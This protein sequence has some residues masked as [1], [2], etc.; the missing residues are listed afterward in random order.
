MALLL[1][2]YAAHCACQLIHALHASPHV[3]TH[4]HTYF[5]CTC[6][7]T[8]V[9]THVYTHIHT[10]LHTPVCTLVFTHVHTHMAR[11]RQHYFFRYRKAS[12]EDRLNSVKVSASCPN[13]SNLSK[14]SKDLMCWRGDRASSSSRG[15]TWRRRP[16]RPSAGS[17]F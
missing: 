7:S 8:Y 13:L 4:V 14:S 17:F 10:Q 2:V 15:R 1:L 6:Q 11:Y 16:S 9:C 3:H 12:Q 5:F